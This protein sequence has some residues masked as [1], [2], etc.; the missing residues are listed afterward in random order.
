[1]QKSTRNELKIASGGPEYCTEGKVMYDKKGAVTAK[2]FRLKKDH[3][4]LRVYNCPVCNH[5]HLT[6][7]L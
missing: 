1:M 2:N 7:N 6:K 4:K 5:W 3:V